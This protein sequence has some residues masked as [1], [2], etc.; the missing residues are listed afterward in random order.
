MPNFQ[1]PFADGIS[2]K[3]GCGVSCPHSRCTM[4]CERAQLINDHNNGVLKSSKRL[5]HTLLGEG[6]RLKA[7]RIVTQLMNNQT[8]TETQADVFVEKY[9]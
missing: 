6:E 8:I 3:V 2:L 7:F 4:K 5:I 9:F 1:N